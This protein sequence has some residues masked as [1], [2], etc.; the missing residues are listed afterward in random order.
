MYKISYKIKESDSN[1]VDKEIMIEGKGE[2]IIAYEELKKDKRVSNIKIF[3]IT[4][5]KFNI[6]KVLKAF[7]QD[8][9]TDE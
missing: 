5:K 9:E 4:C 2:L 7:I 8:R 1:I 3:E 6:E